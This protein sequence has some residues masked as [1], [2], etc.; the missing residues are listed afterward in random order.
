MHG[1]IGKALKEICD[2]LRLPAL[3]P[4]YDP[5]EELYRKNKLQRYIVNH[6]ER[7]VLR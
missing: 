1:I 6:L 3:V 7:A 5:G 2:E 4:V